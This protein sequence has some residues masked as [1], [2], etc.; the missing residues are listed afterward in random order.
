MKSK[1]SILTRRAQKSESKYNNMYA[2]LFGFSCTGDKLYVDFDD[3]SE[4][5]VESLEII[6]PGVEM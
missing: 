3:E 5:E 4:S 2:L 6:H 1:L